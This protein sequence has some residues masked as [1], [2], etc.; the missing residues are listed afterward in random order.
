MIYKAEING[1]SVE[2]FYSEESIEQ[3]FL[4]LL[5][6]LTEMQKKK[7]ARILVMLAAPPGSGKSTLLH[8][9]KYL[10]ENVKDITAV[11]TI[12]MDGFHHY[13]EYLDCHTMIRDGKEYLMKE[14]KG[15]PETFDLSLLAERVKKVSNGESC[16]WPEYYRIAH[17]RIDDAITVD[18]DIVLLEGNYL[19]LNWEGWKELSSYADYTIKIIADEK[20]LK[21]RL[22]NRKAQSGISKE[23]A[24]GFV[25]RSDLYNVRTCLRDSMEADL[26][27]EL[28]ED[29]SY[30]RIYSRCDHGMD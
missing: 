11:T 22:V 28:K 1:L 13:Q 3:I 7:N 20:L 6:E 17:N 4:P 19:L 21:N 30:Q 15:A 14:F 16:G 12:G 27:L 29:D 25:E 8:F 26:V 10:S 9:L 5:R 2:A 18:G 23:D 24:E